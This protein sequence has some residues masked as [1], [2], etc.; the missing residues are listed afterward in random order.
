M[1]VFEERRI[2]A[3]VFHVER[4]S[5]VVISLRG[6]RRAQRERLQ[7][8][9]RLFAAGLLEQFDAQPNDRRGRCANT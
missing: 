6:L 5:R 2:R 3:E 8:S 7:T 9:L 4:S 1:V